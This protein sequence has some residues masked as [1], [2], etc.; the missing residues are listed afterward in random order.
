MLRLF[1]LPALLGLAAAASVHDHRTLLQDEG[2][3]PPSPPS[4]PDY[5]PA[6][7][8]LDIYRVDQCF[9]GLIENAT[10]TS[11]AI[12]GA[13]ATT[14]DA[15]NDLLAPWV[16]NARAAMPQCYTDTGYPTDIRVPSSIVSRSWKIAFQTAAKVASQTAEAWMKCRFNGARGGMPE[17][18]YT[19]AMFVRNPSGRAAS[20]FFQVVSHY[21]LL[22]KLPP[23][24]LHECESAFPHDA[25][26]LNYVQNANGCHVIGGSSLPSRCREAWA[27]IETDGGSTPPGTCTA[28]GLTLNMTRNTANSGLLAALWELPP[29]CRLQGNYTIHDNLTWAEITDSELVPSW[30]CPDGANCDEPCAPSRQQLAGLFAASLSD[31]AKS[32]GIGCIDDTFAGEHMWDQCTHLEPVGRADALIRLE[33]LNDDIKQFEELVQ[34]NTGNT[35]PEAPETCTPEALMTNDS[36]DADSAVAQT[37]PNVHDKA[38]IQHV[39]EHSPELQRR[40]CALYWRDF[41]CLG[42]ELL[43]ACRDPPSEWLNA[44]MQDLVSNAPLAELRKESMN[45]VQLGFLDDV[46]IW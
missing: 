31:S 45:A 19:R 24:M 9:P 32:R 11:A 20:G 35:L 1:L 6:N 8:L 21:L 44:T 12:D 15:A 7:V 38:G 23:D 27:M 22:L 33:S 16:R 30:L 39:L 17:A 41:V 26:P 10:V 28:E 5:G 34:T 43:E 4:P 3:A 40:V 29:R 18:D 13:P 37:H 42:Y 14:V 46:G 25:T 36:E 2:P